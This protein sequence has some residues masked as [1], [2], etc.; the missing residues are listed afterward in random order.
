MLTE[1]DSLDIPVEITSLSGYGANGAYLDLSEKKFYTA[2]GME[3][4]VS[5]YLID[6]C[7]VISLMPG[8]VVCFADSNGDPVT[9]DYKLTYKNKL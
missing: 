4:D 3:T 6:E 8:A 1:V 5:D 2:S 9:A 7:D